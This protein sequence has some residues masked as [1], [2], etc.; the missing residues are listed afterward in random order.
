MF[1]FVP[2]TILLAVMDNAL[3]FVFRVWFAAIEKIPVPVASLSA[4]K[5]VVPL[6]VRSDEDE[7]VIPS[8]AFTVR[9]W[10]LESA[11]LKITE[12]PVVVS[13]AFKVTF[14]MEVVIPSTV[15]LPFVLS[16]TIRL[17]AVIFANSA[18]VRLKPK[19][20]EHVTPHKPMVVPV[21][22]V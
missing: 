6:V 1:V 18:A 13:V 16:P 9:L 2:S 7:R 10:K 17:P 8:L 3:P 22:L 14:A 20:P 11:E 21:E 5:L 15:I 4:L 19:L 12:R